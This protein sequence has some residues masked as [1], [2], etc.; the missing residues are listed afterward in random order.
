MVD[1]VGMGKDCV[2]VVVGPELTGGA[3]G[4]HMWRTC[5]IVVRWCETGTSESERAFFHACEG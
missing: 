3:G 2:D 4:K 1:V 5:C